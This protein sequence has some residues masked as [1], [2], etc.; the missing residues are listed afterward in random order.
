MLLDLDLRLALH[1]LSDARASDFALD[2]AQQELQ[3]LADVEPLKDLVLVRDLEVEICRGQVGES[4][5]IRDVHLQDG[6]H[7]VRNSVDQLGESLGAGNDA[8]D[9]VIDLVRVGWNLLGRLDADDGN[10]SVCTTPSTMS[11]R[12][13]WS[14]I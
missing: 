4:A 7:F 14:V 3:A 9:E 2:A 13:P 1:V 10:G 8:G 12:K 5:R 11:R 6:G